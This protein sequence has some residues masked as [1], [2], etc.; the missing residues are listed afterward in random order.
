M[1]TGDADAL[2]LW[3]ELRDI[4]IEDFKKLYARLADDGLLVIAVPDRESWDAQHFKEHWAAWDVPRHLSHF[5][6]KDIHRL[7]NEHGFQLVA[8]KRMLMDAAYISMLSSKY[9]GSGSLIGLI[10]GIFLGSVSN[11]VSLVSGR[12]TSSSLYL[13]KKVGG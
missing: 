2:Q 12:P 8:T 4:S 10:K 9:Q 13:A 7:L 5:R 11:L 3:Q 1:E 6:R